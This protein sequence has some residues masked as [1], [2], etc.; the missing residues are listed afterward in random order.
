MNEISETELRVLVSLSHCTTLNVDTD[1]ATVFFIVSMLRLRP[2][3]ICGWSA[4]RDLDQQKR[5]P[6]KIVLYKKI[7]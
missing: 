4:S 1:T 5:W 2:Q 7:K 6:V 3:L